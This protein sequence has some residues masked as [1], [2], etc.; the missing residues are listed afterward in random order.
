MASAPTC[1]LGPLWESRDGKG[2]LYRSLQ[3]CCISGNCGSFNFY[4]C[5]G[6]EP[7]GK[8]LVI[9]GSSPL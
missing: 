8:V 4:G 9:R 3:V 7:I 6:S 5:R 1:S 2:Q